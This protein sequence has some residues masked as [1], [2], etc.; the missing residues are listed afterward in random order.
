M[1]LEEGPSIWNDAAGPSNQNPAFFL[2]QAKLFRQLS[3]DAR[4]RS[5]TL[6][7]LI[8]TLAERGRDFSNTLDSNGKP[9]TLSR[10]TCS[11]SVFTTVRETFWIRLNSEEF[12]R[13]CEG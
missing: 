2:L 13:L 12:R 8:P 5:G 10:R 9:V 6:P 1:C 11:R 4:S 7:E 3:M